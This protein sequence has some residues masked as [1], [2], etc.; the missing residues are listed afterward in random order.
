MNRVF[1]PLLSEL[2][3]TSQP[4]SPTV[5]TAESPNGN[6]SGAMP[7]SIS[8]GAEFIDLQVRDRVLLCA[9]LLWEN[10]RSLG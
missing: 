9:R 1:Q 8:G 5:L 6:G 2:D 3:N 10:R 7:H 4:G